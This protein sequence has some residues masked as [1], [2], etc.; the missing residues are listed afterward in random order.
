MYKDEIVVGE[1]LSLMSLV[2]IGDFGRHKERKILV[3]RK[4]LYRM[5]RSF[6]I[7]AP[8]SH[9]VN[10]SQH[11][12]IWGIIIDFNGSTFVGAEGNGMPVRIVE[13]ADNA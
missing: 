7:M 5:A 13:L 2:V 11:L 8:M 3:V 1:K 9:T 10:N 12:V 6:E 4:D